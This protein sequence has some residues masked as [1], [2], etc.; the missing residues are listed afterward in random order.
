[1][2][3]TNQQTDIAE[4]SSGIQLNGQSLEIV[5]EFC[6]LGDTIEVRGGIWQCYNKDQ[7]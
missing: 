7:E 3:H 4:D 1:M 2:S 6:Y 5:S